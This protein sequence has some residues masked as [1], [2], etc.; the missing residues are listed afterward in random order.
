[1][2]SYHQCWSWSTSTIPSSSSPSSSSPAMPFQSLP[3][4]PSMPLRRVVSTG[5]LEEAEAPRAAAVGRYSAEERRERID[6]YRSKRN[7]R[8]FD[9]KITYACRKTLADSRPRVKGRFARNSSSDVDAAA[10]LAA[11]VPE[12]WPAVQEALA[13]Q[14]HEQEQEADLIHLCDAADDELLAAYLGVSS[15]DLYS[16]RGH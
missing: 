10:E 11:N 9:R 12:W 15:I 1:M 4:S 13:R 2:S 8:N 6:K 3:S 14:E 7:Q 5:G 16:P